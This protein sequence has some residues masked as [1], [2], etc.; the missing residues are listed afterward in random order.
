MTPSTLL[1]ANVLQIDVLGL[2]HT[3][4]PFAGSSLEFRLQPMDQLGY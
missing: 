4:G 2:K 1:I 3:H